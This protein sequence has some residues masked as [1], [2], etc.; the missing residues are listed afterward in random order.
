[1][2]ENYHSLNWLWCHR[3]GRS[4]IGCRLLFP[5]IGPPP[6][7]GRRRL[8]GP[9][10]RQ[11]WGPP[12]PRPRELHWAV[13]TIGGSISSDSLLR[14]PVDRKLRASASEAV[15]SPAGVAQLRLFL[16]IN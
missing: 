9:H 3:A 6:S 8:L 10:R 15:G 11:R 16:K 14:S 13:S 12:P 1:M 7:C 2:E 5:L 4:V